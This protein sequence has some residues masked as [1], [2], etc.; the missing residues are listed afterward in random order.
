MKHR[1]LHEIIPVTISHGYRT[2]R[3]LL[4]K[5]D[6]KTNLTQIAV[7]GLKLGGTERNAHP[8]YHG[9]SIPRTKGN[10]ENLCGNR[11]NGMPY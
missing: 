1:L 11:R 9:G 5:E 7:T 8:P 2:K 4:A 3:V 10:G 6:T